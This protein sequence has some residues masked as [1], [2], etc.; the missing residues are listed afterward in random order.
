M[1]VGVVAPTSIRRE[2]LCPPVELDG[3][4]RTLS[5]IPDLIGVETAQP[6]DIDL[7]YVLSSPTVGC[8]GGS[9]HVVLGRDATDPK[10]E[11]LLLLMWLMLTEELIA[12]VSNE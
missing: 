10:D 7:S 8:I 9:I 4:R 12:T 5:S 3:I 11:S 1:L 6:V 2:G